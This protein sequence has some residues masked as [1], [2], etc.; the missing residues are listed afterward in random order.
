MENPEKRWYYVTVERVVSWN[1]AVEA[2]D[3]QEAAIKAEEATLEF[4][5]EDYMDADCIYDP[6]IVNIEEV[7]RFVE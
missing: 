6:K 1:V 2:K 7:K 4:D 3:E 5:G